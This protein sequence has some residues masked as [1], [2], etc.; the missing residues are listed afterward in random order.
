MYDI[1][2][3]VDMPFLFKAGQFISL[4]VAENQARAFSIAS[5]PK[6]AIES[7][8]I[9]LILGPYPSG[10]TEKFL[11]NIKQ[12]SPVKFR[13]PFGIFTLQNTMPTVF[14][15]ETLL[16]NN[17]SEFG[18]IA[19]IA[20]ST[21]IAPHLGMLEYLSDVSY[22]KQVHLY[23]GLRHIEDIILKE[24]FEE[25]K[26]KLNFEYFYCLSQSGIDQNFDHI[27]K[28]YVT[29]HALKNQKV[30]DYCYLCGS[31]SVVSSMSDTLKQ[32]KYENIFFE[33][34]G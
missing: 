22:K 27:Y 14:G 4:F 32:N 30:K 5:S 23:L 12:G 26:K 1:W 24:E 13:G 20:T 17:D 9:R 28:G 31:T 2:I 11:E 25:Y 34:Y 3:S 8:R 10:I 29:E 18:N 21:G 15:T 7:N 33:N 6:H 19:F 16:E